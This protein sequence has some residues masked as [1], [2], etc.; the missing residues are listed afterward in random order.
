LTFEDRDVHSPVWSPDGEDI[1][2]SSGAWLGERRLL[3]VPA[4]CPRDRLE[5]RA[6]RLNF[7]ENASTLSLSNAN[8]RLV[9]TREF[10]N[11]SLNIAE[12]TGNTI[13]ARRKLVASSGA[14]YSPEFSPDGSRIAF[15]STRSGSEE[16]WVCDADGSNLQQLTFVR[17]PLTSRPCWSPDGSRIVFHSDAAGSRDLYVVGANGGKPQRL[18]DHPKAEREARWSRD[19]RWIY[20]ESDRTG[21]NAIYRMPAT[22]GEAV[23]LTT[24]GGMPFESSD[25]K[26]VFFQTLVQ[27]FGYDLWKVP[28]DSG[29]EILVRKNVGWYA[30][31]EGGVYHLGARNQSISI[32]LRFFDFANLND[33]VLLETDRPRN[34]SPM[35]LTISPDRRWIVFPPWDRFDSDLMLVENF[36]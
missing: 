9:Y 2:F 15:T 25:G 16:I 12:L 18:T 24:G 35:G 21:S 23:R 20:F 7:G 36:R 31:V 29:P 28:W 11:S 5:Y 32:D 17:G 8:H 22:G 27:G 10:W 4:T 3:K 13:R 33:E 19:G 26:W 6:V 14:N 30:A 34:P 1:I